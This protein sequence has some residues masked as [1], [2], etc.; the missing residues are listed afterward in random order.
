MRLAQRSAASA[1]ETVT[2]FFPV[3]GFLEAT[4]KFSVGIT[5]ALSPATVASVDVVCFS[6]PNSPPVEFCLTFLGMGV[7][8]ALL[9]H[10]GNYKHFIFLFFIFYCSFFFPSFK[11]N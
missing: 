11:R 2:T 3:A 5:C 8:T 6:V 7:A 1:L 4:D 10:V 9:G